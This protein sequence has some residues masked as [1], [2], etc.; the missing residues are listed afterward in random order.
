MRAFV[1][2][3]MEMCARHKDL[4]IDH[5]CE[6]CSVMVCGKCGAEGHDGH[7]VVLM[8]T[9]VDFIDCTRTDL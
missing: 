1:L 7:A 3:E 9:E 8:L 5:L 2:A 6:T 4:L